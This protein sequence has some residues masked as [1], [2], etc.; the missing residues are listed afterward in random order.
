M[1]AAIFDLDDTLVDSSSLRH[2]RDNKD[3]DSVRAHLPSV[4]SFDGA[5]DFLRDLKARN[6]KVGLVTSSPKWYAQYL[7]NQH[8]LSV[9]AIVAHGD[10]TYGK[11]GAEP[12]RKA[13]AALNVRNT[14]ALAIGDRCVDTAAARGAEVKAIAASWSAANLRELYLSYPEYIARSIPEAR[15]IT[16]AWLSNTPP[17]AF[18]WPIKFTPD[19]VWRTNPS[20]DYRKYIANLFPYSH[21]RY[22]H[23]GGWSA[24]NSN[25]LI[26][27]FKSDKSSQRF[28]KEVAAQKFCIDLSWFL[29]PQAYVTYILPSTKKG[30]EGY[31]DRWELLA[32]C[33]HN[34]GFR[35]LWP[36]QIKQSTIPAHKQGSD[37]VDRDPDHIKSNLT[38]V[39]NLPEDCSTIYLIDDVITKGGHMRAYADLIQSVH[40]Q[41]K[42]HCVAWAL[43]TSAAWYE[44]AAYP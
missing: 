23:G 19:D 44:P 31:D 28:F 39:R 27:N 38:W 41:V 12:I 25:S 1:K 26:D 21:A 36:I 18:E 22:R 15:L 6:C 33:L 16:D 9:D 13:L 4:R 40:P 11:P 37:S 30:D 29:P 32:Q 43:F 2:F 14:Q 7:V 3:W 34:K 35:S 5:A 8:S 20:G 42:V 17:E 24:T 10:Y